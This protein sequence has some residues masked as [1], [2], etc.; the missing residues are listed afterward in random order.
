MQLEAEAAIHFRPIESM[1]A[2]S[3]VQPSLRARDWRSRYTECQVPAA[4]QVRT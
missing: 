3:L 2:G 1:V 4:S